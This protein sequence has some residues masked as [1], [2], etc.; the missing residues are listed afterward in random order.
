MFAAAV[1]IVGVAVGLVESAF[2]PY[3]ALIIGATIII[4][5]LLVRRWDATWSTL[6]IVFG[7]GMCVGALFYVAIGLFGPSAPSNGFGTG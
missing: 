6:L 1:G 7:V 3:L 2:G 4:L 5:G